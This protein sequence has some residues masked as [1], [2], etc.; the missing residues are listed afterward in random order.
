MMR[1]TRVSMA[2]FVVGLA[3]PYRVGLIVILLA[4]LVETLATLALPW[5]LKVVID[6]VIGGDPASGWVV[7]LVGRRWPQGT[8]EE[9]LS[10][11]GIY[12][13]LYYAKTAEASDRRGAA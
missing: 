2:V 5:P 8:H 9:L 12:A 4:M 6:S 13:E 7:W 10:L 3:R 1:G 11:G